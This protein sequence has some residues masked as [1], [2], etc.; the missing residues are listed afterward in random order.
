MTDVNIFPIYVNMNRFLQIILLSIVPLIIE[1]TV[2]AQ[3][4]YLV[5]PSLEGDDVILEPYEWETC[6][7]ENAD[8]NDYYND[9]N[10]SQC[11]DFID[12][13]LCN[14][15]GENFCLLRTRSDNYSDA[16][17]AGTYE[18][19]SSQLIEPFNENESYQLKIWLVSILKYGVSDL[20][21]P[22]TAFPLRFQV[23]GAFDHCI[24]NEEDKLTDTLI[25]NT[26]W[27]LYSLDLNPEKNYTHIYFRVYWDDNLMQEL[28]WR[29]NGMMLLDS[30]SIALHC[31]N[32]N[33]PTVTT[34]FK[35][36]EDV[37][38][39]ATRGM[40]Y[41]WINA[42]KLSASNIQSPIILEYDSVFYVSIT[43][44]HNCRYTEKHRVLLLC[45]S[46]YLSLNEIH[47]T[48]RLPYGEKIE[49]APAIFV[50]DMASI[51][52]INWS[53]PDY[54]SCVQCIKTELTVNEDMVY[55][56][57]YTDDMNCSFS[58]TFPI[59]LEIKIPNVITPGSNGKGDGIND[60][61]KIQGLPDDASIQIFQKSG[62]LIFKARPYNESNWWD[63]KDMDGK[64]VP[65]GTYWFAITSQS[66]SRPVKGFIFVKRESSR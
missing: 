21:A 18:H 5:N 2:K 37:Y 36:Y 52:S 28:G 46:L 65:S 7:G 38:L 24:A 16:P 23:F 17:R 6:R 43:D 12:I 15:D 22:D 63:G 47:P 30:S 57:E 33:L 9:P 35:Y 50:D 31:R 14:I 34:Y 25:T 62:T 27:K 49:L 53:P 56:V 29:Y 11:R 1:G 41:S 51:L 54:L 60:V 61:F 48:I 39:H 45:D 55:T 44:I 13:S 19:I 40:S 66:W 8:R 20:V 59:K 3:M 32:E 10:F 26:D 4:E 58:E 42:S 64:N